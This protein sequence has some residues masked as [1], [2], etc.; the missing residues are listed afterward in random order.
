[1]NIPR[2]P[3][4]TRWSRAVLLLALVLALLLG[5][6]GSGQPALAKYANG[7][8]TG[9]YQ[10]QIFWLEWNGFNFSNGQTR[11]FNLGGGL[12]IT[13]TVSNVIGF[14]VSVGRPEDYGPAAMNKA[15]PGTGFT[16]IKSCNGCLNRFRLTFT[17]TIAGSSVPVDLVVIDA[18]SANTGEYL[19][20]TTDGNSWQ[21]LEQFQASNLR[22]TF[23]NSDKTLELRGNGAPAI[24]TALAV[25]TGISNLDFELKGGGISAAALGVVV[26]NDYG[27][28]PA[29]YGDAGHFIRQTFVG[30]SPG[31]TKV[32]DPVATTFSNFA[33]ITSA[34]R[35]TRYPSSEVASLA[36]R[37]RKVMGG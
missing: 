1:L 33:T 35:F 4:A 31:A 6:T 15:Y 12:V 28:A 14:P 24:G 2:N 11:T 7:S 30:G 3:H 17:A 10:N 26:A 37:G 34:P 20:V 16:A 25:S 27:D 9:L 13:A 29:S 19:K 5:V 8:G 21:M 22:A 18:E 32:Y 23:S 36:T